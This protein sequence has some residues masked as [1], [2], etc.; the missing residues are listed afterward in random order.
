MTTSSPPI[1]V[2]VADD[3]AL[4]RDGFSRIV[5]AQPD[6]RSV[7]TA[8]D[9]E[10]AVERVRELR[11]DVVLMDIRM[12]RLDGIEATRT[13]TVDAVSPATRVLGLT[14]YDTDA[15][16]VRILQAGAVGFILKDSTASQLVDA[17]RAVH[18]GTFAVSAP[19]S[20]RLLERIA[21]HDAEP[22]EGDDALL[23]VLTERERAVFEQIVQGC[24]NPE[25]ASTLHIA[26]VTVKTHV[27]HILTK[28]RVRDRVHLVIWA[29][30]R[31]LAS[32]RSAGRSRAD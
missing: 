32:R 26:E 16:A 22:S 2:L 20:R 13:L 23:A 6:M 21:I 14:T 7:G 5:D 19:T 18:G 10:A 15:Y 4:V 30:E 1:T 17:I 28:L 3:Q 8:P 12:P 24:S 31:G 9:G 11:P 27:G 25:I 29:H